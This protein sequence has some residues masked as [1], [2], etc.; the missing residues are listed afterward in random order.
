VIKILLILT[1]IS[2]NVWSKVSLELLLSTASVKQGEIASGQLLVKQT[3]GQAGLSGL[4][5]K[6]LGNILYL[7]K[8]SPFMGKQGNLESQAKVIFLAV[9]QNTSISEIINGEEVSISWS[10]IQVLPTESSKSFLF[11]NFEIPERKKIILWILIFL[12]LILVS[13]ISFWGR[14]YFKHKKNNANKFKNLKKELINC[15]SYEEIVLMWR[16]KLL[17]L[18][19]FP[20]IDITFKKF[21]EELFKYQFKSQRTEREVAEVLLAYQKFKDEVSGVLN[22]L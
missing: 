10:N 11:G 18:D 21:E 17:Y 19:A 4:Q 8:V 12:G 1:F 13:G 3:E 7:L 6:K 15:I 22:E 20:A 2:C 5:G 16:Q 9:P 14:N